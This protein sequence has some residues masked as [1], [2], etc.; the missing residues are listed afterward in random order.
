[1]TEFRVWAPK[2]ALV[3]LDVNGA[4]HAMTRSDDGWWHA[5]VDAPPDARYGYLLDDDPTVLPLPDG[6]WTDALTGATAGGPTSA[7]ELF[8][9]LPVVLLVRDHD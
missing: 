2:P 5:H 1:M 7:A 8:A 3:R 4:V 9:D 6:S